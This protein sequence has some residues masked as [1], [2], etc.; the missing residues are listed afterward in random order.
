MLIPVWVNLPM[1]KAKPS[2]VNTGDVGLNKALRQPVAPHRTYKDK[3][4]DAE[5]KGLRKLRPSQAALKVSKARDNA[6]AE[7]STKPRERLR[8]H[9]A[10]NNKQSFKTDGPG[11]TR[12][13]FVSGKVWLSGN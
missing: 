6:R 5:V 9:R 10:R 2:G 3:A 4:E 11:K 7:N 13:R 8:L 1:P 12:G